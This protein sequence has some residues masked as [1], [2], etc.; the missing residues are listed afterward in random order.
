METKMIEVT[1]TFRL[2]KE[3]KK[4]KIKEARKPVKFSYAGYVEGT[5][6]VLDAA[7]AAALNHVIESFA[8]RLIAENKED[9]NFVPSAESLNIVEWFNWYSSDARGERE[10][11]KKKLIAFGKFYER[12]SILLLNKSIKAASLGSAIIS[13]RF[14]SIAGDSENC[15][16][17]LK[18]LNELIERVV[19][20]GEDS[21]CFIQFTEFEGLFD[22]LIRELEKLCEVKISAEDL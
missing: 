16:A 12:Y 5:E 2:T 6:L 3:E 21:E 19:D 18:N 15:A 11:T 22:I 17:M 10:V 1:R 9:V 14:K 4:A 13:E 7:H 8:D 20:A